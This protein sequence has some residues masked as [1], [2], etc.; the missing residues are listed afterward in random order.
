MKKYFKKE[1][2]INELISGPV[3]ALPISYENLW[4]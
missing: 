4:L 3:P 2:K 1:K